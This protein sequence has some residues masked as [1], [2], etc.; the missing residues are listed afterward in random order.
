MATART[1]LPVKLVIGILYVNKDYLRETL[2][3]LRKEFGEIDYESQE[4]KFDRTNYY[5]NEMAEILFRK[6]ISVEQL[7]DPERLK[8]IK[9]FTNDIEQRLMYEGKRM[10]NLDPGYLTEAKFI[11]AS[12]KNYQHR[13]YLGKGIFAE[14]ELRWRHGEWNP[15][16]WTYPDYRTE[17]YKKIFG[18]IR[19]IF[20]EQIKDIKQELGF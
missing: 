11:L 10:V 14:Q 1:P 12:A 2:N 16:E 5:A 4:I 6:F 18:E 17:E 7:I 13:I 8:A 3:L 19:K 9:L 15:F 20:R